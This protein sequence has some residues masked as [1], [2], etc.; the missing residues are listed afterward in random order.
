MKEW[1]KARNT[2]G[3]VIRALPDEA[4]GALCKAL[5][6][7]TMDGEVPELPAEME[8]VFKLMRYTLD[9]DDERAAEKSEK[10]AAAGS[11]G[12]KRTQE[13]RRMHTGTGQGEADQADQANACNKNKKK[14]KNTESEKETESEQETEGEKKRKDEAFALFWSY[15]PRHQDKINARQAFD[16]LDPD[17]ELL[18]EM[19]DAL[20]TQMRSSQWTDDGGQ[21][22]PLASSWLNG[23]RWE[24]EIGE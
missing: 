19:M 6:A 2:W 8:Q 20:K 4:A 17:D 7:Y 24:D 10:K 21:F 13:N 18:D 11:L 5:W 23:R 16:A 12:G 14:N 15:Y 1:F 3:A 22:I 9:L